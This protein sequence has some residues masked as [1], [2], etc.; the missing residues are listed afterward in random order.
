MLTYNVYIINCVNLMKIY[1]LACLLLKGYK[2]FSMGFKILNFG[3]KSNILTVIT[4]FEQA[5][6]FM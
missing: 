6:K 1:K 2:F 3:C 5:E 4:Q